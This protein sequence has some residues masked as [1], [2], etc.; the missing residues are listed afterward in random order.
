MAKVQKFFY[1]DGTLRC[2]IPFVNGEKHGV[3]KWFYED[4]TLKCE[5]PYVNGKIRGV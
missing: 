1:E 3:Q 4:G 2:E 5:M